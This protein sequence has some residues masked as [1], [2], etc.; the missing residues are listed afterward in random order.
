MLRCWI[1]VRS[2]LPVSI[3]GTTVNRCCS[4]GLQ[5]MAAGRIV[6][7]GVPAMIAG[8]LKSV[9]HITSRSDGESGMDPWFP[10]LRGSSTPAPTI[11]GARPWVAEHLGDDGHGAHE[12][13]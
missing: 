1:V 5:A 8:D 10:E 3:G 2:Q 6:M 9:S 4:S 11:P 13:A 7:E 12:H